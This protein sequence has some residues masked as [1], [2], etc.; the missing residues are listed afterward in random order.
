MANDVP[1]LHTVKPKGLVAIPAILESLLGRRVHPWAY[2]LEPQGARLCVV[3]DRTPETI[4]GI[5]IP[6][7]SAEPMGAGVILSVGALVGQ[8]CAYPGNPSHT[9]EDLLYRHVFF[10]IHS[11]KTVQLPHVSREVGVFP[12]E[13]LLINDRDIHFIDW[14]WAGEPAPVPVN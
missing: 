4:G 6:G 1:V 9:P 12:N 7:T 8:P 5:I 10:G 14:D 11:G 3:A 2:R 13:I